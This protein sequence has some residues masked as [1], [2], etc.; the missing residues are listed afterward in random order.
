MNKQ[1]DKIFAV[2]NLGSS[3]ITA[4]L[5]SKSPSGRIKPISYAK[6]SSQGSIIH[7]CIH[8][9][10]ELSRIVSSLLDQLQQ[11]LYTHLQEEGAIIK[12]VYIGL[13]CQSM[14]SHTFKATLSFEGE[15]V[16][17]EQEHLKQLNEQA[18][19]KSFA[20][21]SVLHISEP[22]YFVDG[23]KESRPSGVRCRNIV[24]H[25]Q[26]ITIRQEIKAN[27]I[28]VFE[29]RLQ[30]NIEGILVSPLAEAM[31]SLNKEDLML[32]AAYINIGG[33]TTSIAIY[34]ERVLRSFCVLPLGGSNVTRDLVSLKLMEGDAEQV[35]LQY[36]SM[37]REVDKQ[38]VINAKH[39]NG[40]GERQLS[41]YE[42]NTLIHARMNELTLNILSLIGEMDSD[43]ATKSL[44]LAGGVTRQKGYEDYFVA[45]GLGNDVRFATARHD[46]VEVD[47]P[48]EVLEDY[49]SALGLLVQA[50]VDC[51]DYPVQDM[52][53][54]FGEGEDTSEEDPSNRETTPVD[55]EEDDS[56]GGDLIF[57][58]PF[59]PGEPEDDDLNEPEEEE[60]DYEDDEDTGH[61]EGKGIKGLFGRM[62]AA[63]NSYLGNNEEE[64]VD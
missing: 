57:E 19:A 20:G 21:L 51:I 6:A 40:T 38:E 60:E 7:G 16:V 61:T 47:T 22:R 13:D 48:N 4:M 26:L 54:L 34:K 45:L 33:G 49:A 17:L 24:A 39:I 41:R 58:S 8:N 5:A 64:R 55:I 37:D 10:T 11:G 30:L 15:A 2:I 63:V 23:R 32:G 59:E 1:I 35:K 52:E 18:K 29:K 36:G 50:K 28:E 46:V 43:Q 27:I 14:R 42:V 12:R 3:Y 31:V 53:T 62:L 9:V 56:Q 44:V 25:Y